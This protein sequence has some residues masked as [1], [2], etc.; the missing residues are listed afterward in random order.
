VIALDPKPKR[1]TVVEG[2]FDA[3]RIPEA[4][5]LNIVALMGS[6][7]SE[8]QEE[9]F[10]THFK[11]ITLMPD[12]DEAGKRATEEIALRLARRV[13]VRIASVLDGRQPDELSDD[14]LNNIFGSL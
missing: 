2:F 14:E 10:A 3:M 6:L 11:G 9:L 12:G 8:V 1:V 4:A 7:M 13:F 5:R